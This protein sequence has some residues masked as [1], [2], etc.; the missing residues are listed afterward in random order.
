M[1]LDRAHAL[2]DAGLD[3]EHL[4]VARR[5]RIGRHR[6]DRAGQRRGALRGVG[7]DRHG[8]AQPRVLAGID[9]DQDRLQARGRRP[10]PEPLQLQPGADPQHDVGAVPQLERLGARQSERVVVRD[11]AAAAA[12]RDDRRLQVLGELE[13]LRRGVLRPAADHDHRL[14]RRREQLGGAVERIA[15]GRWRRHRPRVAVV[16]DGG[17]LVEDLPRHGE[18]HGLRPSAAHVRERLGHHPRRLRRVVDALRPLRDRPHRRQL[19]GQLVQVAEPLAEVRRRHLAREAQ[20]R[21]ARAVG[22]GDRRRGVEEADAR[23]DGADAGPA[24]RPRVAERHVRGRL[25]V[26]RRDDLQAVGRGVERVEEPVGLHARDAEHRVD[27]VG[28]QAV[29]DGL[30]AAALADGGWAGATAQAPSIMTPAAAAR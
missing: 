6:A 8:G 25:L 19:V 27:P 2:A 29:D 11:D 23:H 7:D 22:R 14:P 28:E 13:Y 5:P 15:V 16:R 18:R 3:R 10:P 26:A 4:L 12:K 24:R 17:A 30:S 20:H 1:R 9:V 21:G